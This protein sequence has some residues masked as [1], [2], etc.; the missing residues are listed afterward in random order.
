MTL[1]MYIKNI[2]KLYVLKSLGLITPIPDVHVQLQLWRRRIKSGREAG[3][4][5]S[6]VSLIP[7][8]STTTPSTFEIFS[9]NIMEQWVMLHILS[10]RAWLLLSTAA[11][12]LSHYN[13]YFKE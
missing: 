13:I 7:V 4:E 8:N 9:W 1:K 2:Y 11:Y 10:V 3:R 6:P 5:A 12:V